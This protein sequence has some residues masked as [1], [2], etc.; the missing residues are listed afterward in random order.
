MMFWFRI[1]IPHGAFLQKHEIPWWKQEVY[2]A[3][4]QVLEKWLASIFWVHEIT[5]Q[6]SIGANVKKM[7]LNFLMY[8]DRMEEHKT[9]Q[10][11]SFLNPYQQQ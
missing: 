5:L 7:L 8:S 9:L 1:K 3:I 10:I 6:S 2:L 4:F 11:K